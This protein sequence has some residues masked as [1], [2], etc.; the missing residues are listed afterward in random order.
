MRA[1]ALVFGWTTLALASVFLLL[2]IAT[3]PPGGLMFALPFLLLIPGFVLA[4]VGGLLLFLAKRA[5]AS[6]PT[7]PDPEC[8]R[9]VLLTEEAH[10]D[11]GIFRVILAIAA[12]L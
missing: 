4:L 6:N 7:T 9:G 10:P 1:V 11:E 12:R 2:G 8:G 3:W 5:S